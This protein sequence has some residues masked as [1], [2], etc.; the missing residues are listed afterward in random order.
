MNKNTHVNNARSQ[1]VSNGGEKS[2][3][4]INI[5]DRVG[6]YKA[7]E[8][9]FAHTGLVL[10]IIVIL[11]IFL[12]YGLYYY[13]YYFTPASN[14]SANSSYYGKNINTY[15]PLF[16]SQQNT[17]TDCINV[18]LNDVTCDGI[19]Y[20]NETQMCEGTK[21]G[22][23]RNETSIY[24]A[25]VKPISAKTTDIDITKSVLIGYTNGF[26]TVKGDTIR[27]PFMLG[28]FCYSFNII[29]NDFYKNFGVWRHIFHKGSDISAGTIMNYQSW[30]NLVLDIPKQTI[31]VWLAPFNNNLRIAIT[32]NAIT[33]TSFGSYPH[34]FVQKCTDSATCYVT[35]SPSGKWTDT[36]RS[37]DGTNPKNNLSTFIEYF[38]HDLQNIP[39]NR[40]VNITI[41]VRNRDVEIY[42]NGKITKINQLEGTPIF[43]KSNL[44]VMNDKTVNCELNNLLFYPEALKIPDVNKIV[45]MTPG[46]AQ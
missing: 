5:L 18:C 7:K 17:I 33:N 28:N 36:S 23:L 21:N 39:L 1:V 35:D 3:K 6:F 16:Q 22:Q 44:Y 41:N 37:S 45:S 14:V 15:E 12:C 8:N 34:A 4:T 40:Y 24:S 11:I 42:I 25:W 10:T 43:D 27:N 26:R 19:T 9:I 38:D 20:N 31:G 30:E 46:T 32:T 29:I 2:S 13:Y